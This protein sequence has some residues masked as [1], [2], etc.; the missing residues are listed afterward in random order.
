MPV[1]PIFAGSGDLPSGLP[2]SVVT[3]GGLMGLVGRERSPEKSGAWT[4][5]RG[6]EPD[7]SGRCTRAALL[8][9]R[10]RFLQP[11]RVPFS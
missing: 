5:F 11:V 7:R 1:F 2:P 3:A 8:F 4:S 6:D 9:L 10:L